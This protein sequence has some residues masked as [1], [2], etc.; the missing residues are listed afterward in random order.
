MCVNSPPSINTL[1]I[2]VLSVDGHPGQLQ[3]LFPGGPG[4][5]PARGAVAA[6]VQVA[7]EV[8]ALEVLAV[9]VPTSTP[10]GNR[11]KVKFVFPLFNKHG[12]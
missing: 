12:L 8:V 9:H 10:E 11:A 6:A 5:G 4:K 1:F 2:Y 7:A 3:P